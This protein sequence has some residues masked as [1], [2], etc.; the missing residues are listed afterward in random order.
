VNGSL[1]SLLA[2]RS[3]FC[4]R[5]LSARFRP[6]KGIPA[7]LGSRLLSGCCLFNGQPNLLAKGEFER[8]TIGIGYARDITNGL[9][10]IDRRARRTTFFD[11]FAI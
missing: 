3:W 4:E 1:G 7:S 6:P 10:R 8:I 9:T 5:P 11:G 2:A